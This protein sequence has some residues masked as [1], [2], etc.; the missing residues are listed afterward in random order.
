MVLKSDR[1]QW[2]LFIG[3]LALF[4]LLLFREV[5]PWDVILFTSDNN[6]GVMAMQKASMPRSFFGGWDDNVLVG[7]PHTMIPSWNAPL[8]WLLPIEFYNSWIFALNLGVGSVFLALFLRN[9][10]CGWAA[11][12]LG[13]LAALW[14]GSNFTLL[15]AGHMGKFHLLMWACVYLWAVDRATTTSGLS[16]ALLSG[17]ALGSMY[18]EQQDVAFFFSVPLG[19]YAIYGVVRE[20]GWDA[21]PLARVILPLL[22][23]AFL[24]AFHSL[25]RGYGVAVKGVSVM[26]DEDPREKWNYITQWSWPPEESIDFIAMGFMGWRSGNPDGPYWGR[27]GRT[28]GWEDTGRGFRNFKL[29][30]QYIGAVPLVFAVFALCMAWWRRRTGSRTSTDV[31]FWGALT[32]LALVLSFGKF[33]P[34]YRLFYM[35]PVVSSIRN[36]NKFL[37]FF[38]LGL[39]VMA[40][41]GLEYACGSWQR[42]RHRA[43]A[44]AQRLKYLIYGIFLVGVIL[45]LFALGAQGAETTHVGR[46]ETAGWG[47]QQAQTI[48]QNRITGL[49]HGAVMSL[50]G[51]GLLYAVCLWR[52]GEGRRRA[53]WVARIAVALVVFDVFALARH[54][55]QPMSMTAV[56]EN[57]VIR[58]LKGSLQHQRLALMTRQG[59]YN[60][61]L[62]YLFPYH[63]IETIDIAQMPRMPERYRRFIEAVGRIPPR[64]WQ[65]CAVGYVMGPASG[66]AQIQEN[67]QLKDD[68]ELAYAFNVY[69]EGGAAQA[70]AATAE[71]PGQHGVLRFLR[72]ASRF[73][74]MSNWE[75]AADDAALEA[76]A[77]PEMAPLSRLFVAPETA[78]TL[79]ATTPGRVQ[80]DITLKSYEPGAVVLQVSSDRPTILRL[81]DKYDPHWKVTLDGRPVPALRCDYLFMGAYVPAGLHEVRFTYSPP[82]RTVWVHLLGMALCVLAA[83]GVVLEHRRRPEPE[84]T[85]TMD[86]SP[87]EPH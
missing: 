65:F 35:L 78:E 20:K 66:W 30:N 44:E 73:T 24:V 21:K 8:L 50:F 39:A 83:V 14:V 10:G 70:V 63:D 4:I 3:G 5:I 13:V 62:T 27:M 25:W 36:P 52:S 59:F 34:V 76:L 40:A 48:V 54:Y 41:Y 71:N 11:A 82:N 68:Y 37:Q 9:R 56:R 28:T 87:T 47:R 72:P 26:E 31:L 64:Y 33:T 32:L 6:V 19:L 46:L 69:D 18:L 23:M 80:G 29:E 22:A 57:D 75:I 79:P 15:Y 7:M 1:K 55:V 42:Y 81:S 45:G 12:A 38:Q 74:L 53:Q 85:E 61:W 16:Y 77:S 84:P 2:G 58:W 17:G 43:G 51:G 67:E 49:W 86:P 60:N